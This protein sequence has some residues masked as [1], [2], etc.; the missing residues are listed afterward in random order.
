MSA[1]SGQSSK[2]YAAHRLRGLGKH[3]WRWSDAA[4]QSNSSRGPGRDL[5]G[6]GCGKLAFINIVMC[7]VLVIVK[8][9]HEVAAA[10]VLSVK[11]GKRA[12]RREGSCPR[13][14]GEGVTEPG[15]AF[16]SSGS[17][18]HNCLMAGWTQGPWR[19][20]PHGP[21]IAGVQ[22]RGSPWPPFLTHSSGLPLFPGQ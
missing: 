19:P 10:M 15:F 12:Q 3:R 11:M 9:V 16:G 1:G 18:E 14:P 17:R 8:T 21:V 4:Q 13:S 22:T 6:K 5:P 20:S 7:Q 2:T